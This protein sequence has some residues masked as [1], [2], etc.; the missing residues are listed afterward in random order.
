M[1]RS[2]V[3]EQPSLPALSLPSDNATGARA[4]VTTAPL[5]A[6][7]DN[8]PGL[9][10]LL[11]RLR[12]LCDIG[13]LA[14]RPQDLRELLSQALGAVLAAFPQVSRAAVYR[15]AAGAEQL[16]ALAQRANPAAAAQFAEI[17]AFLQEALRLEFG[18]SVTDNDSHGAGCAPARGE[19]HA[20]RRALRLGAD[21]LGVLYRNAVVGWPGAAD[22]NC[23]SASPAASLADRQPSSAVAGTRD[24]SVRP[25]ALARVSSTSCRNRRRSATASPTTLRRVSAALP[26]S[27]T[28]GWPPGL[29]MPMFPA[30]RY[31]LRCTWHACRCRCA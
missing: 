10:D 4:T 13:A 3:S 7:A 12:L 23:L 11:A 22:H 30:R 25:G 29:V 2:A 19:L 20:A 5:R 14:R 26:I 16:A 1:F 17:D 31:Q 24:R 27:S 28:S 6:D 9:R 8:V 18:L 21:V 15:R